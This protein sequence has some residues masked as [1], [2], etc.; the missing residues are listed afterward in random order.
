MAKVNQNPMGCRATGRA[1]DVLPQLSPDLLTIYVKNSTALPE[2]R[3]RVSVNDYWDTIQAACASM[4]LPAHAVRT[5]QEFAGRMAA[6]YPKWKPKNNEEYVERLSLTIGT[7]VVCM[8]P[9]ATTGGDSGP[10]ASSATPLTPGP[11]E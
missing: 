9:A 8:R 3:F 4:A 1:P 6:F 2:Y 11:P 7:F 10:P 5:L